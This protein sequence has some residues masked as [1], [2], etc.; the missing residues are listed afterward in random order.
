AGLR[1]WCSLREPPFPCGWSGSG[2]PARWM[3]WCT[4][5]ER[6]KREKSWK[7]WRLRGSKARFTEPLP[8]T[9][10]GRRE[11]RSALRG[12][13]NCDKLTLFN[14]R[15][16]RF[17]FEREEPAMSMFQKLDE[18]EARFSNIEARLN[19]PDLAGN[20]AELQKLS[21]EHSSL[22]S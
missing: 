4:W 7:P 17:G 12:D 9:R 15:P 10:R 1:L 20:P 16:R 5:G 21:K 11:A 22:Q 14:S 8:W 6:E 19:S 2:S 13:R 3:R 18:V